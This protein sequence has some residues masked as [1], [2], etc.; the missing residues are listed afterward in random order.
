MIKAVIFDLDG[1]LLYTLENLTESTNYALSY[2]GYKQYDIN[3][4]RNFVGDGVRK[5]IERTIPEGEANANFEACL[6]I[7]KEHYSKTM[8]EKTRPYD[9]IVEMLKTLNQNGITCAVVSNKFDSAVKELCIRY[10]GDLIKIA[11][12]ECTGIRKKPCPDG[13]LNIVQKLDCTN[14]CLYVGDSE[15]D[16]QTAKNAGIPCISVSWGYKD[17]NFLKEH[18]A[19]IIVDSIDELTTIILAYK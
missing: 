11:N 6:K 2:F 8:Y 19:K 16:V 7:F 3:D 4:I 14:S 5:L 15:V 17:K 9:G 12:G 18:D 1:T 13:V 10:F